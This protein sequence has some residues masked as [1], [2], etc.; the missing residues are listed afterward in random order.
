VA[1]LALALGTAASALY[2]LL[3]GMQER[4][5]YLDEALAVALILV[6]AKMLLV[7]VYEPPIW[8]SLAVIVGT[9]A[10]GAVASLEHERARLGSSASDAPS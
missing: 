7:D 8:L 5:A 4:F 2:F 9:L 3:A 10:T 1:W 6:G